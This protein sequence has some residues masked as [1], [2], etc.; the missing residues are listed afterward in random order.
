MDVAMPSA[1]AGQVT[2]QQAVPW[3]IG[4][5]PLLFSLF[6]VSTALSG[7]SW[8]AGG[9]PGLT[10]LA[11]VIVTFVALGLMV[12]E[13]MVF[14]RRFGLGGLLLFGGILGWF[15]Y[16]YLITWFGVSFAE[17]PPP[18]TRAT[19]AK[20]G[21]YHCLFFLCAAIGLCWRT[22]RRLPALI[23][24]LPEPRNHGL[25]L[26]V[27]VAAFL[28]GIAPYFLFAQ[29]GGFAAI[30]KSIIAG[31]S[32]ERPHFTIGRTGN[33][34]YAWGGY[35]THV[36]ETGLVASQLAAFGALLVFRNIVP[37]LICASIWLLHA[38]MAFGSGAR[39]NVFAVVFPVC[40]L[41]Y[42]RYQWVAAAMLRR[43]SLRAYLLAGAVLLV[44][45]V[46]FQIQA[47]YRPR[48][49]ANI[50]VE[51]VSLTTLH[52]N[53][54]FTEGMQGWAR[55][56]D[57]VPF[58]SNDFPG[59]GLLWALPDTILHLV[60]HPI[61][62]ALWPNKPIDPMWSWYN[63]V[64]TGRDVSQNE[65]TTI[66]TGLVAE[67]YFRYGTFGVIQGGLLF[68][69]LCLVIERSLLATLGRPFGMMVTMGLAVWLLRSFRNVAYGPLYAF[70]LPAMVLLLLIVLFNLLVKP[71]PSAAA[72]SA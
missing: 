59:H 56:P 23:A 41:L 3:T 9:M 24:R 25:Y 40:L 51:E 72:D 7:V 45:L 37:R 36:V 11:F 54:M 29:E 13:L 62:R 69:W 47:H 31:R 70:I 15:C 18:I 68:G 46:V 66:S 16:D 34:N 67:W 52:G 58:F 21:F 38:A 57:E 28:F 49:F 8:L 27:I 26:A 1:P 63:S 44:M 22:P 39:G 32:G 42:L 48:G 30:Y 6:L 60:L 33:I 20:A 71:A 43:F 64:I 17:V 4:R 19:V 5:W 10:D 35:V 12:R 55:I 61:P 53:R 50:N 14:P 2:G 65:G